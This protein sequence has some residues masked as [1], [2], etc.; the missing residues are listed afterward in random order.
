MPVNVLVYPIQ[1]LDMAIEFVADLN[2]QLALTPYA[3]AQHVKL[4]V[5]LAN[6][7]RVI[8]VDLLIVE[9]AI[10]RSR[11]G[12]IAIRKQ[13]GTVGILAVKRR[14]GCARSV[15]ETHGLGRVVSTSSV[16]GLFQE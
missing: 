10:V 1:Q 3:L 9:M 11:V 15:G 7:L 8:L 14:W 6:N 12:N 4:L 5:L 2:A 13:S 16:G